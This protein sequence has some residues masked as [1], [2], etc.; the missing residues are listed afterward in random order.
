MQSGDFSCRL[1]ASDKGIPV[2]DT[3]EMSDMS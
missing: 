1:A 2:T 3:A